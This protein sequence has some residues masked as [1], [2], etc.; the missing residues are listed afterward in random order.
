[1]LKENIYNNIYE[2]KY[3]DTCQMLKEP[4]SDPELKFLEVRS[5]VANQHT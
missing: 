1:V 4:M 2:G 5:V 3:L